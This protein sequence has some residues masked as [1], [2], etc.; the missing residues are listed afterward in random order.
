MGAITFVKGKIKIE[1]K[2]LRKLKH[3]LK[4]EVAYSKQDILISQRKYMFDLL[5]ET[6]KL[7]CKLASAP[8]EQNH[9]KS[10]DEESA[11]FIANLAIPIH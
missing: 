9:K 4:I 10:Y 3:F 7:E 1:M 11:K 6:G 8:I 5:Q 2:D